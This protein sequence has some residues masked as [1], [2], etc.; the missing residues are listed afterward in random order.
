[1]FDNDLWFR[2]HGTFQDLNWLSLFSLLLCLFLFNKF[3]SPPIILFFRKFKSLSKKEFSECWERNLA[4]QVEKYFWDLLN[5]KKI[6][7][8]CSVIF[9][10]WK[11]IYRSVILKL[12]VQQKLM[13]SNTWFSYYSNISYYSSFISWIEYSNFVEGNWGGSKLM[14]QYKV[15]SKLEEN[16]WNEI[17]QVTLFRKTLEYKKVWYIL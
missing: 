3:S 9:T 6:I 12:F 15:E 13:L 1:M 5:C 17:F 2:R 8:L 14:A 4:Q 10:F 11:E 16:E 7:T